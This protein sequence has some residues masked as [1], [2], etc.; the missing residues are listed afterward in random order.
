MVRVRITLRLRLKSPLLA[1]MY[2]VE[3]PQPHD[4][5]NRIILTGVTYAE[6]ASCL[7]TPLVTIISQSCSQ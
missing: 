4:S 3:E 5:Q 6:Y 7:A 2:T 1:L